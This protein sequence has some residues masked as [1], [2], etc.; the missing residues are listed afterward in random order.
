MLPFAFVLSAVLAACEI[1]MGGNEYDPPAATIL[2]V[3]LEPD[4]AALSD[5]ATFTCIIKQTT[6]ALRYICSFP[7]GFD[8]T[9]TNQYQWIASVPPGS[10]QVVIAL[11]RTGFEKVQSSARFTVVAKD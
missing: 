1:P 10:Y 2:D 9:E 3:R 7:G 6:S 8:G 5:T 11:R 4:P